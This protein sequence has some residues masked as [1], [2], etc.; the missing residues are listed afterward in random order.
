[1]RRTRTRCR[2]RGRRTSRSR[3]PGKTATCWSW[4]SPRASSCI[5]APATRPARCRTR[6]SRTTR[7][8]SKLPRAGI[9][10]RLDKDT[11]GLLIV[12]R[13]EAARAA[14]AEALA[15][16]GIHREYQA[17]CVGVMTAG[18]HGGCADRPAPGGSP[19]HGRAHERSRGRHALPRDRALPAP[20]L[21]ARDARDR[22]HA[23]DPPAPVARR[24]SAGRRSG[25][26]T[27]GSRSRAARRPSSR[28]RCTVSGARRCTP[29]SSAF[30]IRARAHR[31]GRVEA[32]GGPARLIACLKRDRDA[33]AG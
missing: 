33:A 4:T 27:A 23:P 18:R 31:R 29:R 9:V 6:C 12:A 11:S 22:P 16:R 8:S 17:V 5:L 30:C 28:R 3:S 20:Y 10:H 2:R 1:M 32:A 25:L 19:A 24:L 13:N 21:G 14:L 15:A 7:S 26:R